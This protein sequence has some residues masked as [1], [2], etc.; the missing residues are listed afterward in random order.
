MDLTLPLARTEP[1]VQKPRG[2]NQERLLP[3]S[4]RILLS[5]RLQGVVSIVLESKGVA[6]ERAEQ[7]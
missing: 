1:A 7:I 3:K 2:V 4:V 6:E 5:R